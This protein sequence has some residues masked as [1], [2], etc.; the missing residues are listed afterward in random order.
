MPKRPIP[1]IRDMQSSGTAPERSAEADTD[2]VEVK[3]LSS[4]LP[5]DRAERQAYVGKL[6]EDS[7]TG[8]LSRPVFMEFVKMNNLYADVERVSSRILKR[9]KK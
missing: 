6:L 5:T 3:K 9:M 2:T 8:K 1:P 7:L 4:K